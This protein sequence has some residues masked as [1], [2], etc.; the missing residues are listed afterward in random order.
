M[1]GVVMVDDDRI[2]SP[3]ELAQWTRLAVEF[4]LAEQA[5]PARAAKGSLTASGLA[6]PSQSL[7]VKDVDASTAEADQP[8][9]GELSE[10]LGG[11]L[12]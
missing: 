10:D 6:C 12:A 11:G 7:R 1:R 3:Q 8:E 9:V 4:A 2:Q 5:K